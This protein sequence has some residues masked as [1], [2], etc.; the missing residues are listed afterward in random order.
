MCLHFPASPP[1]SPER[2]NWDEHW[3]KIHF[4]SAPLP[5]TMQVKLFKRCLLLCVLHFMQIW[6]DCIPCV[7]SVTSPDR[8]ALQHSR[9]LGSFTG[10]F[11]VSS[12]LHSQGEV[13]YFGQVFNWGYLSHPGGALQT[14]MTLHNPVCMND[15]AEHGIQVYFCLKCLLPVNIHK[16][17]LV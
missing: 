1:L 12:D 7:L 13:S 6:R 17:K 11:I 8:T 14:S 4:E 10:V 5:R 15:E 16:K 2:R 9:G 3:L